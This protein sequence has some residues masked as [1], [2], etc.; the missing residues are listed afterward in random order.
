MS[1]QVPTLNIYEYRRRSCDTDIRRL[2]LMLTAAWAVFTFLGLALI[3][4][5][6]YNR[7]E[8]EFQESAY[9]AEN[10]IKS[11][12]QKNEAALEGLSAYMSGL[13]HFDERRIEQYSKQL[14]R[15]FPHIFMVEVAQ[16]VNVSELDNFVQQQRDKGWVDFQV[17]AF[18]YA[19][20][21]KW[22]SLAEVENYYPLIYIYPL[23]EA[24]KEVLGL[25]MAAHE[26]LN[27]PLQRAIASGS[28][29][30]STPFKLV[31][32]NEAYVMFLP[33][34][35]QQLTT[36]S[37][38]NDIDY[39]KFLILI[40]LLPE[41]LIAG[42][43]Q[44]LDETTGM[45]IYHET[46]QV[47][48]HSGYLLYKPGSQSHLLPVLEYQADLEPDRVGFVLKL[49][50]QFTPDGMTIIV[51]LL[52]L[53]ISMLGYF[54]IRLFI[55]RR[56]KREIERIQEEASL[57]L[58]ASYD[59]LTKL[60]N[61]NV[62]HEYINDRLKLSGADFSVA[63]I[64]LDLEKFK[65]INDQFGHRVGDKVLQIVAER[66]QH[67]LRKDDIAVRLG[68]D[69]F[70]VLINNFLN[71][72]AVKQIANKIREQLALPIQIDGNML[73][74][75]TSIGIAFYP[76]DTDDLMELIS[77]ADKMMYKDKQQR[78]DKLFQLG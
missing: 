7:F 23:R 77:L 20:E 3:I 40:V 2:G 33:V 12:I 5:M 70:I 68:G 55:M 35:N 52:F 41:Y 24:S 64:F 18:D 42:L 15:R 31:E 43:D 49:T 38:P 50:K 71:H 30:T 75:S 53:V 74:V 26:H 78:R 39:P 29:Q 28:Y 19:G 61:R 1:K 63:A 48:D 44:V 4:I 17:K 34:Y 65:G 37:K 62:L 67:S 14:L 16:H 25:D 56:Y 69:E 66:I 13:N 6:A 21:R 46:K 11:Q 73:S 32:G 58:L 57:A 76:D 47:S 45:L 59:A 8:N 22:R 27:I 72:D 54:F 36:R 60:P 10:H 9:Q 51:I